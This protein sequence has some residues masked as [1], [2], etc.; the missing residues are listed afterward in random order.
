MPRYLLRL[1]FPPQLVA[2]ESGVSY[3][4]H[5]WKM[6]QANLSPLLMSGLR[7]AN[8]LI[9]EEGSWGCYACYCSIF[10]GD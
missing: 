8:T 9:R 1:A 6:Y 5:S 10:L 4:N 7:R 2:L 3:Y